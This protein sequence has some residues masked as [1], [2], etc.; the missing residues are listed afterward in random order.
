[1]A[2][3]HAQQK[4]SARLYCAGCVVLPPAFYDRDTLRVARDLLGTLL[5]RQSREGL[6][7]GRIV[8]VEAYLHEN[9][10]ACHAA[11]GCTRSNRAMFGPPGRAYVYPIHSRYCLNAVTRERGTASAVLIRAVEPLDGIEL[12]RRR[13]QRQTQRQLTLR[14]L[15]RGPAR[16]CEAFAVDRRL[17]HW[18]L[19]RGQRLWIG[20]EAT[21]G[22]RDEEIGQSGRIGV[23]AAADLPLRFFVIS[24]PYVSGSRRSRP[25]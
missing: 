4:P 10:P 22:W 7:S 19:T 24:S 14:E 12:M 9:D 17:D 11:R 6:T 5:V 3:K 2:A 13:R 16:L 20:R 8:E 25:A 15:V 1:M 23:T 21:A 18:D